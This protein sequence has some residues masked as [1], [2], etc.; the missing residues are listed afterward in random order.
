MKRQKEGNWFSRHKFLTVI[1]AVVV[2]IGVATMAS[3][4]SSQQKTTQPEAA[5]Q[6]TGS[7]TEKKSTEADKKP[8]LTL[9]E[10]WQLDKSNQYMTK[11]VGTVSNNSDKPINGYIQVTFS[12]LDAS[13]ANVGDCLANANT[14]DAGGKWKFEAM[15]SGSTEAIETVR[16]K[17][18]TGF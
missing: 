4:G 7:Q 16:F 12:A 18:I 3:G 17:D 11:V 10:G 5:S 13:G 9:D 14:V 8:R 15:C 1:I 2:L 6:E